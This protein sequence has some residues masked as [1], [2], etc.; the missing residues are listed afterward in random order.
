MCVQ[1]RSSIHPSCYLIHPYPFIHSL[2]SF[3]LTRSSIYPSI[4]SLFMLI[5]PFI[6]LFSVSSLIFTHLPFFVSATHIHPPIHP[7][8]HARLLHQPFIAASFTHAHSLTHPLLTHHPPA[9][10][11]LLSSVYFHSRIQPPTHTLPISFT[12]P[13]TLTHPLLTYLS[14]PASVVRY[15]F[16]HIHPPTHARFIIHSH[17]HFH[18]PTFLHLLH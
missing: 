10:I 3:T 18:P 8:T 9:F 5:H 13:H 1:L 6:H 14:S 11:R 12:H 2:P 7:P 15:I 4:L 16:T 17:H